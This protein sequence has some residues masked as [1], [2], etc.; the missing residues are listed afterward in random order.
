MLPFVQFVRVWGILR[1]QFVQSTR[2]SSN[3]MGSI[4]GLMFFGSLCFFEKK[5]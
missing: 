2:V 5:M 3:D 4:S 1:P